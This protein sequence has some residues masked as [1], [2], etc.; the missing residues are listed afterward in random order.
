L[1]PAAAAGGTAARWPASRKR[2][3]RVFLPEPVRV[4]GGVLC[5]LARGGD[6]GACFA[7][8]LHPARCQGTRGWQLRT[9]VDPAASPA[10][11]GEA[12][13]ARGLLQPVFDQVAAGKRPRRGRESAGLRPFCFPDG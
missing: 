4:K 5:V 7:Q 10:A 12:D 8:S 11:C 13:R 1:P 2:I 3:D 6:A 9:A